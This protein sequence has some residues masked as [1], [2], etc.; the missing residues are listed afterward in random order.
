MHNLSSLGLLLSMYKPYQAPLIAEQTAFRISSGSDMSA[1]EVV[2][3]VLHFGQFNCTDHLLLNVT[4]CVM[5]SSNVKRLNR[6]H[7]LIMSNKLT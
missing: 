6:R 4:T 3:A 2:R 5:N 7:I 1:V